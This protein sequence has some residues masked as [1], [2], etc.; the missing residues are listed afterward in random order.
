MA[1][2]LI[3]RGNIPQTLPRPC[4]P[5]FWDRLAAVTCCQ[6]TFS[7]GIP[8]AYSQVLLLI[9]PFLLPSSFPC[10]ENSCTYFWVRVFLSFFFLHL[11]AILALALLHITSALPPPSPFSF[12]PREPCA[13]S[14]ELP[15]RKPNVR[16][17]SG[18]LRI[19]LLSSQLL[20][21]LLLVQSLSNI[22]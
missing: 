22:F 14:S 13:S 8:R 11:W 6:D 5:F 7:Y 10:S 15:F 1:V 21:N 12:V 20:N 18:Y 16:S 4:H 2:S 19:L 9:F 3:Q 17:L